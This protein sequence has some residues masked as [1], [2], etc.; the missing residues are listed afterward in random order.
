MNKY[1]LESTKPEYGNYPGLLNKYNERLKDAYGEKA[2]P[3]SILP[4]QIAFMSG[5]IL[6]AVFSDPLL[7]NVKLRHLRTQADNRNHGILAH[8]LKPN[9]EKQFLAMQTVF[10]PIINRFITIY[11]PTDTL[12]KL[13]ENFEPVF[14]SGF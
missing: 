12:E 1:H 6:L 14:S 13:L 10:M 5:A 9:T 4:V 3:G 11:F 2:K 7:E 8:G